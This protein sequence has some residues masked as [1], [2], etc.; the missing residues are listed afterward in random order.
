MRS[1]FLILAILS[2][3][4]ASTP[5][6]AVEPSFYV[7]FGAG[8]GI[9][10]LKNLDGELERQGDETVRPGYSFGVSLGRVFAERQWSLELHF[11]ATFFPGFDY[12]SPQDSF[13]GKLRHYSYMAVLERH[14]RPEGRL[15]RPMLGAG[16]GFGQTSL[17]SGGGQ[18]VAPEALI[19]GR[20][21]SSIRSTMD[22]AIECSYYTGLQSKEFGGP[23]L[24]NVSTDK[25][26]DSD[27]NALKDA[28]RSLDFRIA[29]TFWLKQMGPQ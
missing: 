5:A 16:I 7:H 3:L 25:V 18:M 19:T 22:L 15:I 12:V 28:F 29:F 23:F 4:G 24:E 8:M 13:P 20:I 17:I 2:L 27:G 26:L 6:A 1:L 10:F 9:P 11:A 21:D 14:F